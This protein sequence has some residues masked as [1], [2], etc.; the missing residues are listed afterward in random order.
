[1]APGE[2]PGPARIAR[3]A[4][5]A[6]PF[7]T[8]RE[9]RDRC[10]CLFVQR[11]ARALARRFDDALRPLRLTHGQFSLLNAL[12]RPQPPVMGEV[13]ALLGMDRRT[14]T[15]M[16]K[17]LQRRRLVDVRADAQDKRSRRLI[18]AP[19]GRA[20]LAQ[21]YPR[22]S[23]AHAALEATLDASPPQLRAQLAQL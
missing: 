11:A 22:W 8:T 15:A 21:A 5:P 6:L 4:S 3:R 16:L 20:L 13:A 19:A 7:A 2:R 10:L 18:L 9:V 23:S 1:P 12:N 14:L 17:A